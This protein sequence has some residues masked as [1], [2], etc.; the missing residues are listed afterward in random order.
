M[1]LQNITVN[2]I[3]AVQYLDQ[4]KSREVQQFLAEEMRSMRRSSRAHISSAPSTK[5]QTRASYEGSRVVFK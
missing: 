4:E 1:K 2:G 3:P 5:S